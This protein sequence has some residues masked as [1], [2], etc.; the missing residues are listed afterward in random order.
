MI[1]ITSLLLVVSLLV[2][3]SRSQTAAATDYAHSPYTCV[4]ETDHLP[5]IESQADQLYSYGQY[6]ESRLP[7]RSNDVTLDRFT[8]IARYYRLAAAYGDYRANLALMDLLY[9]VKDDGYDNV[10]TPWRKQRE[11][12][13][14]RLLGQL[15]AEKI[16]AGFDRQGGFAS[17]DWNLPAALSNYRKAADLGNP[18]AQFEAA[19]MLNP[20]TTIGS[21][22]KATREDAEVADSLY[23]CA[24]E[25]GHGSAISTIGRSLLQDGKRD[26]A[27]QVFHKGIARGDAGSA[28]ALEDL[29]AEQQKSRKGTKAGAERVSRYEVI[30]VFL[31]D[32]QNTGVTLPDIEKIVPLPPASLPA[33]NGTFQ[34]ALD[35]AKAKANPP[36]KPSEQLMQQLGR[37]KRLDPHTGLPPM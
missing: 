12:E 31:I 8:E 21:T 28:S 29:F 20:S 22:F 14:A 32:H 35:D 3:C 2:A 11:D 26:E 33:W 15:V 6:L 16:P 10:S 4:H 9:Q 7:S 18:H 34:W 37:D 19:E 1:R 36:D 5:A 25:Q 13:F 30:R 24:A 23:H 17:Q 27:I